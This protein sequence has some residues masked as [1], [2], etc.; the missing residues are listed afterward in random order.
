MINHLEEK[1]SLSEPEYDDLLEKNRKIKSDH[2]RAIPKSFNY[3]V[4]KIVKTWKSLERNSSK[5][6]IKVHKFVKDISK[7]T[8]CALHTSFLD[9]D[10]L[11]DL[12]AL[13]LDL[14]LDLYFCINAYVKY[15]QKINRA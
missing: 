10:D 2:C 14:D 13:D 15:L 6:H 4:D 12:V 7:L 8:Y 1:M 5:K 11:K 9:S 3:Q